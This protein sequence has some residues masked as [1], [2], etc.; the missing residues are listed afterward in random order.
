MLISVLNYRFVVPAPH[1]LTITSTP[2]SPIRPIGTNVTLKCTVELSPLVDVPVIVNI[3]LSDPDGRSLT[4][5]TP[6][7]SGSIYT[8][9]ATINSFGREQSGNHTCTGLIRSSFLFLT[10]SW[11]NSVSAIVTVGEV[12]YNN[13]YSIP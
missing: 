12:I 11:Q 5:T 7:V 1:S 2:A 13:N 9:I 8:T 3:Q 4:A 10:D 6:S